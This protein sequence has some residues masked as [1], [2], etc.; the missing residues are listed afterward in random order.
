MKK[1][2]KDLNIKAKIKLKVHNTWMCLHWGVGELESVNQ[3]W[4][5]RFQFRAGDRIKN[6]VPA[7]DW[8]STEFAT[9]SAG[10]TTL[11]DSSPLFFFL[12]FTGSPP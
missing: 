7:K 11:S 2:F 3:G 8:P 9:L 10:C 12:N 5:K 4:F 1:D 6:S